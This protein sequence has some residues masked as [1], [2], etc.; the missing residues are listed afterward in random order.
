MEIKT[1]LEQIMFSLF[2]FV[3][4][5]V[6]YG[7]VVEPMIDFIFGDKALFYIGIMFAYFIFMICLIAY[8]WI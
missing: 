2:I 3:I 5:T 4:G 6:I 1:I 8:I 7:C